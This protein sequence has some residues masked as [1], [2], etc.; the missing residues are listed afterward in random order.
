MVSSW[1]GHGQ[2]TSWVGG[3]FGVCFGLGFGF[4]FGVGVG[5]PG[6]VGERRE[7]AV[8]PNHKPNPNQLQRRPATHYDHILTME[9]VYGALVALALHDYGAA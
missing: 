3:Q 8:R 9:L 1:S 2:V 4:G 6:K 7:A 5:V